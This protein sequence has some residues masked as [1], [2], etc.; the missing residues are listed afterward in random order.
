MN[1]VHY[2]YASKENFQTNSKSEYHFYN[3]FHYGD[4]ILNL[5][6]LFNISKILK[7]K[8]IL[9]HYYYDN[10]YCKKIEELQRYVDPAV[11]ILHQ[12]TYRPTYAIELWVANE[13]DGVTEKDFD[14]Y[15][16]LF[17]NKILKHLH[18]DNLNI[19][20][21]L[22]QN[23]PYLDEKYNKLDSKF[24][25]IDILIINSTPQSGQF[26]YN[27][28]IFDA[29][30]VRLSKKYKV[31]TTEPITDIIPSTLR[32]KLAMQDIG[33]ISTRV[34]YVIGVHT[35]PVIP[36]LNKMTRDN[37]KKWILFASNGITH[38]EPKINVIPN[39]EEAN[40][41]EKYLE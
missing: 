8:N 37:I 41:I 27:K 29:M 7:D 1:I 38:T 19:D 24:K 40:N 13:I 20:I 4:N 33:A 39:A 16:K 35:G 2:G 14:N 15:I 5:K 10:N 34:K 23:E 36:T 32:D 17:Y 25:D 22:Y 12:L 9:I 30:C 3:R 6:F 21:S 28:E 11:V 18:L 26:K 31:V